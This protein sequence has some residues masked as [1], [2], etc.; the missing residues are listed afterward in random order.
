MDTG[1]LS[2]LKDGV[3]EYMVALIHPCSPGSLGTSQACRI[4]EQEILLHENIDRGQGW[5]M[6]HWNVFLII[7]CPAFF[8]WGKLD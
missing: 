6:T 7:R 1:S 4:G 2:L 5:K 8:P 3:G